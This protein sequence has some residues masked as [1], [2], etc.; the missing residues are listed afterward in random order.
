MVRSIGSMLAC[1]PALFCPCCIS[2]QITLLVCE[3]T[4][5]CGL[6]SLPVSQRKAVSCIISRIDRA[7]P[8]VSLFVTR[9]VAGRGLTGERER[10]V[11]FSGDG[12]AD[13]GL[14]QPDL[15]SRSD[16]LGADLAATFEDGVK[17]SPRV[18]GGI[19]GKGGMFETGNE[20]GGGGAETPPG[21]RSV[22]RTELN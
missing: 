17:W 11:S 18:G 1:L 4:L 2:D 6:D 20:L 8:P 13:F 12:L 10:Q 22:L 14:Q 15:G 5:W 21:P 19:L 9:A 7:A 16:Y 3:P